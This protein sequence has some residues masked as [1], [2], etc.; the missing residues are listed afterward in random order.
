MMKQEKRLCNNEMCAVTSVKWTRE[1]DC[2]PGNATSH[3][4]IPD[5]TMLL[6]GVT[7]A[8]LQLPTSHLSQLIFSNSK[9]T[10]TT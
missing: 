9:V 5:I 8:Y 6:P 4:Q 7:T 10:V 2:A 3:A 1:A